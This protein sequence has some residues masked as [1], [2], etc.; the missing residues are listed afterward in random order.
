MVPFSLVSRPHP[1]FC[2]LQYGKAGRVWYI[3]SRE[4]DVIGKW[5]KFSEQ[6][7]FRVLSNRLHAQR[8]TLSV[9]F[10]DKQSKAK[11]RRQGKTYS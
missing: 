9:Y 11:L 8:S 6:A 4:H 3:F 2:R 5:P 10:T 1:A 7:M